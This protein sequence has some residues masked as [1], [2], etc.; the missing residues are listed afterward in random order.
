ML[1]III[2]DD[3]EEFGTLTKRR[4]HN[5]GFDVTFQNGPFGTVNAVRKG[6]FD[7]AIVDVAMPGLS[8]PDVIKLIREAHGLRAL[9]ILLYSSMDP[10]PLQEIAGKLG[11]HGY[12]SKSAPKSELVTM[13]RALLGVSR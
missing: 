2:I 3:D 5:A 1:R 10:D 8:G 6:E 9:K 4:L 11:A 7:L 12:L 13:A